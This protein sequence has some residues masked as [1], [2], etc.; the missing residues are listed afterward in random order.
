MRKRRINFNKPVL[1]VEPVTYSAI[2]ELPLSVRAINQIE[3][4]TGFVYLKQ[5]M[6]LTREQLQEMLPDKGAK[7]VDEL[8]KALQKVGME[9]PTTWIRI[10]KRAGGKT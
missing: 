2:A 8:A 4:Q 3:K 7:I 5:I 9:V 1:A 6:H 10:K